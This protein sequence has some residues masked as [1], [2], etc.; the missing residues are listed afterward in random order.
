MSDEAIAAFI[1]EAA[2]AGRDWDG[3][4]D[5]A[6]ENDMNTIAWFCEHVLARTD[7]PA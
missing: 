7:D 4:P 1:R 5:T 3:W 6:T 2:A